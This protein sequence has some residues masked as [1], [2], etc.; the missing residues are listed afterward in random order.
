MTE[1]GIAFQTR[2]GKRDNPASIG[3]LLSNYEVKLL[4]GSGKRITTDSTPGELYVRGPGLLNDYKGIP[5]AREEEG[6]FRTG[7]IVSVREG[8]YYLLGRSKE[9]IKV[10]G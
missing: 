8:D 6:W 5:G 1:V 2:Y 3:R 4:D 9:L 7:D 10:R